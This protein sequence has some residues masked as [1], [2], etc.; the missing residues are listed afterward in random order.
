MT[1]DLITRLSKLDAPD[2]TTAT[3]ILKIR[4]SPSC[5]QRRPAMPSK[6]LIKKE[7]ATNLKRGADLV[8]MQG[9]FFDEI[10]KPVRAMLAA[11]ALGEQSE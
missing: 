10:L 9:V 4:A 3:T 1:S 8:E 2:R 5:A 6:E 7:L 11:S